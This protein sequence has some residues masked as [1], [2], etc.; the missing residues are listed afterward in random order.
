[1]PGWM[2]IHPDQVHQVVPVVLVEL[3]AHVVI[4]FLNRSR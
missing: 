3:V 2:V 1:M 4:D